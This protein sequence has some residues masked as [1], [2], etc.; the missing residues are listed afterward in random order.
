MKK[1]FFTLIGIGV[2]AI[3]GYS[4]F[5]NKTEWS[6]TETL[7]GYDKE[8]AAKETPVE[9]F[10]NTNTQQSAPANGLN[11]A[12]GQPGHRCDIAVGAPLTS[13]QGGAM[14]NTSATLNPAHGQP[15]HRCDVAVGAPLPNS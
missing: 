11:P 3:V 12:H 1:L 6:S 4:I 14:L 2:L 9:T 7:E 8:A 15:G 13:P 5:Q 10:K